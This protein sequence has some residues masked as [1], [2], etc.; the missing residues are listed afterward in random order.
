MVEFEPY[1]PL[2]MTAYS[3]SRSAIVALPATPCLFGNPH[4]NWYAVCIEYC[5]DCSNRVVDEGTVLYRQEAGARN[6]LPAVGLK[7]SHLVDKLQV[8]Y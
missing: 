3:R 8:S 6:G 4:R 5:D 7:L 2:F 1:R